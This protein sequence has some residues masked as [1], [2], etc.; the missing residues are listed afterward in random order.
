MSYAKPATKDCYYG[1]VPLRFIWHGQWADPQIL[2][3][4]QFFNMYDIVDYMQ[5]CYEQEG[6]TMDFDEYMKNNGDMIKGFL[7]DIIACRKEV[8]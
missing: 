2:Y 8:L 3:K 5:S 1:I 7:N 6:I 4:R